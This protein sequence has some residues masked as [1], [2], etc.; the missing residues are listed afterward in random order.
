MAYASAPALVDDEGEAFARA[1]FGRFLRQATICR[2]VDDAIEHMHIVN[3]NSR[4]F[5]IRLGGD[6][7]IPVGSQLILALAAKKKELLA[8]CEARLRH[9]RHTPA[10]SA[11]TTPAANPPSTQRHQPTIAAA[12]A[13]MSTG[14]ATVPPIIP[15]PGHQ[16]P[17]QH[18][19]VAG[20]GAN[21]TTTSP[22]TVK[23]PTQS[24]VFPPPEALAAT[25]SP[26]FASAA[27]GGGGDGASG[28]G[29]AVVAA[30]LVP[31]AL[32]SSVGEAVEVVVPRG[33]VVGGT[34]VA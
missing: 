25:A 31:A 30:V 22:W 18:K 23:A 11:A 10:G 34:A 26:T 20:S 2:D 32:S 9:P 8:L 27:P 16:S 17:Q 4:T 15:I 6:A 7:R 14:A 3:D 33:G 1:V 29:S 19:P 24:F 21:A 28:E 12:T 13:P 5:D